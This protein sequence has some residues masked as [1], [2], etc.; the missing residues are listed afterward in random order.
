[1]ARARSLSAVATAA[2]IALLLPISPAAAAPGDRLDPELVGT[3]GAAFSLHT[4]LDGG[5]YG[6]SG[7]TVSR[8]DGETPES[9]GPFFSSVN[10][11]VGFQGALH[12]V[13]LAGDNTFDVVRLEA[14]AASATTTLDDGTATF[15]G[16]IGRIGGF[17]N[18]L[19]ATSSVEN[20][21]IAFATADGITWAGSSYP[22]T[23]PDSIQ[24]IVTIDDTL[25]V[26]GFVSGVRG[27]YRWSVP[28]W[29]LVPGITGGINTISAGDGRL[30]VGTSE[31]L[32]SVTG[33]T[34]TELDGTVVNPRSM[35]EFDG[36]V[37]W[38]DDTNELRSI[39]SE[40]V[41]TVHEI[42]PGAIAIGRLFATADTLYYNT[43]VGQSDS[44]YRIGLEPAEV[45]SP[46]Q[47]ELADTGSND[48]VPL[49]GGIAGGIVVLGGVLLAVRAVL[50]RRTKSG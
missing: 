1:M 35:A 13:S 27:V 32:F 49:I 41:R 10:G 15:L 7:N 37:W 4:E 22:G 39:D 17:D 47:P 3:E 24:S 43:R 28:N 38:V 2:A 20:G 18:E 12:L 19:Y 11:M 34:A 29:I 42:S 6:L 36:E 50:A 33:G 26:D 44:T 31:G 30:L 25:Y 46:G 8:I 40:G 21:E 45:P 23:P 14:G 9:F 16:G 48:L 5:V